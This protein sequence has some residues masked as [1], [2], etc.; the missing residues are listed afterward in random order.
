MPDIQARDDLIL[1]AAAMAQ[2]DGQSWKSF[3]AAL[4]RH[5]DGVKEDVVSSPPGYP[6]TQMQGRAQAYRELIDL[7]SDPRATALKIANQ[8]QRTK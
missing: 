8:R 5:Y 3:I 2:Y 7:I 1:A 6:A 4:A